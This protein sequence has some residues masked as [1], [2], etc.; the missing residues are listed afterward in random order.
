MKKFKSTVFT[1][2]AT[3]AVVS[4]LG[5]MAPKAAHAVAAALV[6]IANTTANPGVVQDSSRAASQIVT[7][8]LLV[9]STLQNSSGVAEFSAVSSYYGQSLTPY[10]VPTGQHLV[11]TT[12]D[13]QIHTGGGIL[14][15]GTI[16]LPTESMNIPNTFS[17][18]QFQFPTGIVFDSGTF[19]A[20]SVTAGSVF[21]TAH[22]YLTAI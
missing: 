4:T 22:G 5:V 3:L 11:I 12:V 13:V 8:A 16:T 15:F 9:P 19:P 20:A 21:V 2:G 1:A 10:S 17:T 14:T 18:Q 7:L 6:Q